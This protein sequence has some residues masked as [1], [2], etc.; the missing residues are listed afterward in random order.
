MRKISIVILFLLISVS[1][2]ATKYYV[3]TTGT[4]GAYPTHGTFANPWLT[5]NYAFNH[6]PSSDTCYFRGGIYATSIGVSL[7]SGSNDGTRSHPTSFFAYPD[8]W[9]TG[10]YPVLDCQTMPGATYETVGLAI[11]KANNLHLKGLTVKNVLQQPPY[12]MAI[13]IYVSFTSNPADVSNNIKFENCTVHNIGGHGWLTGFA[14]TL[15]FINCDTYNNCDSLTT[16]DPGGWGVG[17]GTYDTGYLT[18]E[19]AYYSLKGCRAW[20]CSDQGYSAITKGQVVYDSCWAVNNGN[21]P[22]PTNI[23]TKGSGWKWWISIGVSQKNTAILQLIWKNCLAVDNEYRGFNAADGTGDRDELRVHF[24][25]NF[26]YR[27]GK[28]HHNGQTFGTGFNDWTNIDTVGRWDH[29]YVNNLSYANYGSPYESPWGVWVKD[30][31]IG[32]YHQATNYWENPPSVND[33]DFVSLDTTGLC[34]PRQLPSFKL[35]ITTFGHLAST[36]NLINAGTDVGLP[37]NGIAPDVGWV[38]YEPQDPPINP[39]VIVIVDISAGARQATIGCNVTDDGGA[40]VTDRGVCWSESA[41]PDLSDSHN[42]NGSGTGAFN[43]YITGLLP[44]TTYHVRGFA[45]NVAGTDYTDDSDFVTTSDAGLAGDIVFSPDGNP[46][47]IY[48]NVSGTWKILVK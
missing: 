9:N 17:F 48:D 3:S 43:S 5:W 2:S 27:N 33:A 21:M 6:T 47:F 38:E 23:H 34:G 15:Y 40:E 35:P 28:L 31:V 4:D 19:N 45:T 1:V 25:N 14:D 36:S 16:Y 24:Y 10:N 18:G 44:N 29:W 11:S 26:A 42:H 39:I 41:N 7:I 8:D 20:Q 46:L 32:A 30:C 13:G 12:Y 37:Y 22:F